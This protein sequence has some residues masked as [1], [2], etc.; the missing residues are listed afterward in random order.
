MGPARTSG[1]VAPEDSARGGG[2]ERVVVMRALGVVLGALGGLVALGASYY[3]FTVY[4]VEGTNGM[5]NP[6]APRVG[7]GIAAAVL[8]VG[9]LVGAILAPRRPETGSIVM[10]ASS[11]LG[12]VAILLWNINAG[13]YA[14]AAPLAGLAAVLLMRS[15]KR[16]SAA[17]AW[18]VVMLLLAAVVAGYIFGG[19]LI[20]LTFLVVLVIAAATLLMR[21]A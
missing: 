7:F 19:P 20:G 6:Y 12:T 14:A 15:A 21:R 5:G 1:G 2:G 16:R 8:A 18:T 9:I 10:L 17:A 3:A 4:L 13:W 11:I